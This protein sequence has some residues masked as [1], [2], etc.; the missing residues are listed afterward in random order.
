MTRLLFG[1]DGRLRDE[2]RVLAFVARDERAEAVGK[3]VSDDVERAIVTHA[4]RAD[5]RFDL[6]DD[7]GR[8][9]GGFR[10]FRLRRGGRLRSGEL[11]VALHGYSW[12]H[13]RWSFATSDGH[14]VEATAESLAK[15]GAGPSDV[16]IVLE[17][18][19]PPGASRLSAHAL[20]LAF[21]CWLIAQWHTIA[22]GDHMLTSTGAGGELSTAPG[23][24]GSGGIAAQKSN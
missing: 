19:E 4:G 17:E 3:L 13:D 5:W 14:R 24:S 22:P 10:P 18:I 1:A 11:T 9:T 16:E 23:R 21:G 20:V 6:L 12:S 2:Q 15:R 8:R 7:D